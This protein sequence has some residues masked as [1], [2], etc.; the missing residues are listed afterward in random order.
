MA[1]LEP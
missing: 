1:R